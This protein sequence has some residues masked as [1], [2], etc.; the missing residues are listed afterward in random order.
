MLRDDGFPTRYINYF[1]LDAKKYRQLVGKQYDKGWH[2]VPEEL[3]AAPVVALRITET[4][5][6]N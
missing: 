3:V 4:A 2:F 1:F 6:G 5:D